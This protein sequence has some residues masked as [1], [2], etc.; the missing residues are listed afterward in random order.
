MEY[1]AEN[2]RK[3]GH[4]ST[5][6]RAERGSSSGQADWKESAGRGRMIKSKAAIRG[7]WFGKE[8]QGFPRGTCNVQ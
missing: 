7:F 2:N 3:V 8:Y 5:G 4:Y 1:I 6:T